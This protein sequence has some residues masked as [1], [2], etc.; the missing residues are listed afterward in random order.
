MNYLRYEDYHNFKWV[1]SDYNIPDEAPYNAHHKSNLKLYPMRAIRYIKQS[2]RWIYLIFLNLYTN[3]SDTRV[4]LT[5]TNAF[6]L[7][8]FVCEMGF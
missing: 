6:Y 4:L 1:T 8:K 7:N 3:M 5:R 2:K